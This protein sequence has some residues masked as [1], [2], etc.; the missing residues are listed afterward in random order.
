LQNLD[1]CSSNPCRNGTICKDLIGGYECNCLPGSAECA[2][3]CASSPCHNGGTCIETTDA[4]FNCSCAPGFLGVSCQMAACEMR[5]CLNGGDC[6]TDGCHC[7]VRHTGMFCEETVTCNYGLCLNGATCNDAVSSAVP[8]L[9]IFFSF[10]S[11][12]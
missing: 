12:K 9:I 3:T 2:N 1:E 6:R 5:P 8:K 10:I 11:F 7:S 4:G